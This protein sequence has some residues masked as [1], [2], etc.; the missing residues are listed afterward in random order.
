MPYLLLI[1]PLFHVILHRTFRIKI[2]LYTLNELLC[3]YACFMTLFMFSPTLQTVFL[4]ILIL[5]TCLNFLSHIMLGTRLSLRTTIHH[6]KTEKLSFFIKSA[7]KILSFK[8]GLFILSFLTGIIALCNVSP[9]YLSAWFCLCP[10]IKFSIEYYTEIFELAPF[11]EPLSADLISLYKPKKNPKSINHP[12]PKLLQ[13]PNEH[14]TYLH[15]L[16]K[17]THQFHGEKHFWIPF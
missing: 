3:T 9:L 14:C 6:V 4:N 5:T 7:L 8:K 16:Y 10:L 1:F 2:L 15:N 12:L 11:K 17:H 13:N